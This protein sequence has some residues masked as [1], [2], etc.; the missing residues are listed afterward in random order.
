MTSVARMTTLLP[1][2]LIARLERLRVQALRRSTSRGRGDH[3][4]GRGGASVDFVDFRDYA[5]GDDLR[6]VDWNVF[7]RLGRPYLKLYKL[8][9][10]RHLAIVVDVSRS[11]RF[12]GKL[13]KACELAAAFAVMGLHGDD[14]VGVWAVDGTTR[15]PQ[16]LR[17]AR[18]RQFLRRAFAAL[19]GVTDADGTVP[20]ERALE[21][22]LNRGRG[23]G[24]VV[25]LSD[26]LTAGDL[27]RSLNLV[28]AAGWEPLL[29]QILGASELD[30]ELSG[31]ARL[32]DSETGEELDVSAAGDLLALYHE[33]R[34]AHQRR[35]A[36][37]CARC[38]G[39]FVDVAAS[40]DT[41]AIVARLRR[42]G[43]LA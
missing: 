9:E 36:A 28:A 1:N 16:R 42:A 6:F 22:L 14:R 11:M 33:H 7:S 13:A 17:P 31:D 15:D 27:T 40:E 29:V 39:R 38:Q 34:L 32:V 26:F 25:V 30:P 20:I 3:L 19:E 23:R 18:G 10:E 37:W 21:E 24:V 2:E 41:T 5:P 12:E 4:T 43:W 35:L 8:E